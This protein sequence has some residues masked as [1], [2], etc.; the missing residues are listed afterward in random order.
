MLDDSPKM[1]LSGWVSESAS[2]SQRIKEL[3]CGG[4]R[5]KSHTAS[6]NRYQGRNR[7]GEREG[8]EG[9]RDTRRKNL[10]KGKGNSK[11][12]LKHPQT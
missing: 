9:G 4:G 11:T 3:R 5:G 1:L 12:K 7:D 8:V 2:F 10:H 6:S